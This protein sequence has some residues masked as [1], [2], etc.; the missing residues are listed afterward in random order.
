[1]QKRNKE[2]DQINMKGCFLLWHHYHSLHFCIFFYISLSLPFTFCFCFYEPN[3]NLQGIIPTNVLI[4]SMAWKIKVCK[5][6]RQEETF[7]NRVFPKPAEPI[8]YWFVYIFRRVGIEFHRLD[9]RKMMLGLFIFL[10]DL[11]KWGFIGNSLSSIKI[12]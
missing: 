7:S 12:F 4:Q 1:M 10:I 11:H 2:W 5:D 9:V 3:R 8:C 6:G